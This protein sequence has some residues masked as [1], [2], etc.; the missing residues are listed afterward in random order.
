M[1]D[2]LILGTRKGTFVLE[3]HDGRWHQS[4][5]GH[6]GTNVA[7]AA[8]DPR[9]GTIWAALDHGHWGSKLS[10]S[11]DGGQTW[12][13]AGQ[14]KYPDGARYIDAPFTDP[15]P[16]GPEIR[17]AKVLKLWVIAF[18]GE[19]QPGRI[20]CGTIPGGL[21]VSDD[22][23]AS[24][25]LDRT[26]WNDES[27]GG[28]LFTGDGKGK[29]Q[30]WF[31]TPASANTGEFAAGIHSIDVNPNDPNDVMI[32]VSC[33]GAVQTTDGGQ[34]WRPRNKG[35][36]VDF[37]PNKEPEWGFDVHF[38]QRCKNDPLHVWNQ[39]HV[40][41]Y[42]SDNGAE[43]WTKV[44]NKEQGVHFGWPVAVD[45]NDGRTAWLVPQ[46]SDQSRMAI[47]G[48]LFVART[49]DGGQTWEQLREGLPQEWAFDTIYRHG[50]DNSGD[51]LAFGS[52]NGNLYVSDNCGDS[53]YTIGNNFPPIHSVRFA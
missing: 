16:D 23:G 9:T 25:E 43:T 7:Y 4:A 41:V 21:F 26:L 37:L 36:A 53:W 22:D 51:A 6:K 1:S 40:G 49:Q 33:A 18:G 34:S 50:L 44:D 29:R 46:K 30:M 14:I 35:M 28:D 3:K 15:G 38:L 8:R 24:W 2:T 47:D 32:A 42:Y 12:T 39:N 31:G 45:A 27:R 48:G 13:D 19:S 11:T 10:K 5:H 17:D 20:Y 52:T